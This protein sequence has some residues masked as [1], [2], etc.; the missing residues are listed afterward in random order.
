MGSSLFGRNVSLPHGIGVEHSEITLPHADDTSD[1]M[2]T[3]RKQMY[4]LSF[5]GNPGDG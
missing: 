4:F 2:Q 3:I 1:G 5:G